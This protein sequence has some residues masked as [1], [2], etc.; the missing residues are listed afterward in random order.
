MAQRIELP[1]ILPGVTTNDVHLLYDGCADLAERLARPYRS[2]WTS[3]HGGGRT[4][5][6]AERLVSEGDLSGVAASDQHL[7][8]F[9]DLYHIDARSFT[10]V[11]DVAGSLPNVPAYLAGQPLSMRRRARTASQQAPLVIV[12]DLTSS[13]SVSTDDTRKRGA[14]ILALVRVLAARRPVTLWVGA[15]LDRSSGAA[16]HAW[17]RLD[18]APLDLARATHMLTDVSVSRGILY[19]ILQTDAN[20]GPSWPYR[21]ISKYRTNA[22]ASLSRVFATGGETLLVVPPIFSGEE[23]GHTDQWLN[24]MIAQYGLQSEAA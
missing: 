16:S 21:D 9:E 13:S 11:P 4:Q 2:G 3:W 24:E 20:A 8:R 10:V 18:T 7:A 22:H 19:G 15:A 17:V 1:C 12:V 5:Q 14:A 6:K 23:A